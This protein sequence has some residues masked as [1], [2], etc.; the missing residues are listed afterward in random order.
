MN[1]DPFNKHSDEQL[2]NALQLSYLDSFVQ[3]LPAGLE[4]VVA[5]GGENLSIGQRQLV[6]LARFKAYTH[7]IFTIN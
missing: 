1:L 4:H 6:C 7:R 5:E 2:W 3:T